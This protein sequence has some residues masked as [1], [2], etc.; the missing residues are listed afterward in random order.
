LETAPSLTS[1]LILRRRKKEKKGPTHG[2]LIPSLASGEK[3]EEGREFLAK[4][5]I[6]SK[7]KGPWPYF[8][9]PGGGPWGKKEKKHRPPKTI[10]F[11]KTFM[12]SLL[13]LFSPFEKKKHLYRKRGEKGKRGPRIKFPP[14]RL[15]DLV[16]LWV[17]RQ[18][19]KKK[20]GRTDASP[21][22]PPCRPPCAPP[23]RKNF[24]STSSS[25]KKRGGEERE[26]F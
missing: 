5:G 21:Q 4:S 18:K 23:A 26:G 8:R 19:K 1:H 12:A 11:Q 3:K 10:A 24:P 20:K 17:R 25:R 13:H 9:P 14:H 22:R 7:K 6:L 16:P 15:L 2:P